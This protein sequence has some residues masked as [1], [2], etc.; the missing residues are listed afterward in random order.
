MPGEAGR[1][2]RGGALGGLA[3]GGRRAELGDAAAWRRW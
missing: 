1:P 3:P 2:R